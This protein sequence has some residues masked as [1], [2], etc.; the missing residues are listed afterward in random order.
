MFQEFSYGSNKEI[1]INLSLTPNLML[2]NKKLAILCLAAFLPCSYF[3]YKYVDKY[4]SF[5]AEQKWNNEKEQIFDTSKEKN[6]S[7]CIEE[8][9]NKLETII[10]NEENELFNTNLENVDMT[11]KE[12]KVDV[13]IDKNPKEKKVFKLV[14]DFYKK[15]DINLNINYV[16]N[17]D[18][19][20][21]T[22][23]HIAVEIL[24]TDKWNKKMNELTRGKPHGAEGLA[25]AKE[26]IALIKY[27]PKKDNEHKARIIAHEIGHLFLLY[28]SHQFWDDS[29]ES[30][31]WVKVNTRIK[32]SI[33]G[34]VLI[35][36]LMSCMKPMIICNKYPLGVDFEESQ[37]KIMHSYL[38]KGKV[39]RQFEWAQHDFKKYVNLLEKANN[40]NTINLDNRNIF[41]I[42]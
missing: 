25:S 42:F 17:I 33:G 23:N 27:T 8:L 3:G 24:P 11:K 16:E 38:S 1:I 30:Y 12:V 28:H 41:E 35:P 20:S 36:N 29:L 40:Y 37:K 4:L 32:K 19:D 21:L 10:T 18:Y 13:Y 31:T 39:Y 26:R 34:P 2:K 15:M 14:T 9:E 5:R 7:D 22:H 6:L